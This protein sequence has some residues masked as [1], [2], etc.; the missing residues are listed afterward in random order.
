MDFYSVA[1]RRQ[2]IR[3]YEILAVTTEG[4]GTCWIANFDSAEVE[5]ILELPDDVNP[6]VLTPLGYPTMFPSS[7]SRKPL[8]EIVKFI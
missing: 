5:R 8:G 7:T 3:K 4:L 2:S 1:K 6:I